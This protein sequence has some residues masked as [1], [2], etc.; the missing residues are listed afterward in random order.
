MN[1]DIFNHLIEVES[2]AA[3]ML[4]EAQIEAD[5]K[6][7]LAK[8]QADEEYKK[9]YEEVAALL[10]IK[11][12]NE[13]QNVDMMAEK[14]LNDY[15]EKLKALKINYPAFKHLIDNYFFNKE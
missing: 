7:S 8:K 3:N 9:T 6:I 13:K 10:E 5:E 1:E 2:D 4:F 14:E 15:R 12:S 11:F